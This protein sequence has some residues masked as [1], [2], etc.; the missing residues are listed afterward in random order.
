MK[1]VRLIPLFVLGLLVLAGC[2]SPV[3]NSPSRSGALETT[4]AA[5]EEELVTINISFGDDS[6]AR[7]AAGY[8]WGQLAGAN[9]AKTINFLQLV[10][11][12][13]DRNASTDPWIVWVDEH[14]KT[15]PADP[16]PDFSVKKVRPNHEYAFLL[17]M[18]QWDRDRD[19]EEGAEYLY[20]NNKPTL[21][22]SGYIRKELTTESTQ[23]Q[24]PVKRP[25]VDTKFV[26]T[27]GAAKTAEPKK[28]EVVGQQPQILTLLTPRNWQV[29]WTLQWTQNQKDALGA[30]LAAEKI[31]NPEADKVSV[32]TKKGYLYVNTGSTS[33]TNLDSKVTFDGLDTIT[34]N[35][36]DYTKVADIGKPHS[37]TFRLDYFPFNQTSRG[38]WPEVLGSWWGQQGVPTW[39]IRNGVNNETQNADT[40]FGNY[41]I[42]GFTNN[43][44]GNGAVVFLVQQKTVDNPSANLTIAEG[45]LLTET[46]MEF[47]PGGWTGGTDP[48]VYY[49]FGETK[50]TDYSVYQKVTSQPDLNPGAKAVIPKGSV[51][52]ADNTPA[53]VVL[54]KDGEFGTPAKLSPGIG[55]GQVKPNWNDEDHSSWGDENLEDGGSLDMTVGFNLGGSQ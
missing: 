43:K 27:S 19:N 18:G 55:E 10:V 33:V 13:A 8:T 28:Y 2:S 53:W 21:L 44:N 49:Y 16:G 26:A 9:D 39:Y 45:G 54:V 51:T 47:T 48:D 23:I 31:I 14:R 25:R 3:L 5:P 30:L 52:W 40:D 37:A 32:G 41:T 17:L 20:N 6:A 4:E 35:V 7:S 50:P 15:G 29:E 34:M 38:N 24:I 36:G 42:D 11:V 12:D 22:K 1:I 46:G